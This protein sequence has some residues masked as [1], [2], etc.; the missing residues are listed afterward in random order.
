MFVL[1]E[2]VIYLFCDVRSSKLCYDTNWSLFMSINMFVYWKDL[3][4]HVSVAKSGWNIVI[5]LLI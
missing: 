2:G 5:K 4:V 1:E 3:D